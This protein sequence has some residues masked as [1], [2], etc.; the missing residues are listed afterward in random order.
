MD[1]FGGPKAA[2][3]DDREP[4]NDQE[5]YH[6]HRDVAGFRARAPD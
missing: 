2:S 1:R 5:T 4:P 6:L 3:A